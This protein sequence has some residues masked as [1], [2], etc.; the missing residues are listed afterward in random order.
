M[1]P[2]EI[3][4]WGSSLYVMFEEVKFFKKNGISD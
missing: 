1:D 2:I 3:K 4:V